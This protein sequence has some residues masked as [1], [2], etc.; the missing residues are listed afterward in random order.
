MKPSEIIVAD[1]QERNLQPEIILGAVN[2]MLQSKNAIILQKNDS[3]LL[4]KRIPENNAELHLFYLVMD[5]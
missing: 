1:A 3:V 4:L 5:L 2:R